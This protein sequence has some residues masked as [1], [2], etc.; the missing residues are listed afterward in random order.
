M[1]R[2]AAAVACTLLLAFAACLAPASGQECDSEHFR[3]EDGHCIPA[4]WRCDGTRDCL[5][6]TDEVGCPPPS[7]KSNQFL[8]QGEGL[9]IPNFW[10]CDNDEDCEDGSDEHQ[11]CPGRTCSSHQITCSN[12]ECIPKE[13]RCDHVRDCSDGTDEKD[14]QYP[15]CEQ[16]TCASGACY[17][18]SQK[19]DGRIDCRDSSDE[20][21]CTQECS[22]HEFQCDIGV[23][24]PRIYV[25]DH[26]PDCED[27]GDERSCA[28]ETCR[29]N[30]FT[31]SNGY[32][33]SQN[34]VCDGEDDCRD[35]G[36]ENGC[37]SSTHHIRE[38]YPGEWA[39]PESG[40][41]IPVLKVCDGTL[42]CPGGEDETNITK[43]R[44]C[45]VNLC[46]ILS[47]E[48][49][50]HPSPNGG[51]CHCPLGFI[52]DQ[53]NTRTCVDFN[54]CQIWGICDQMC[55]DR[56]G[57]HQCHC[58]EGYVLEHQQHCKANT[59]S[60]QASVIFSNGRDLLIG[61]IHGRT[62]SMLVESQN[63]G[64]AVGVDFHY[65]LHRVFWTDTVQDKV[66]SVDIN[67]LNIQEVVSLDD[68]ENLAVD[69]INNKLYLVETKVNRID[70]VNIDGSHR[71]T[72]ITENLGH[73]RGIAV[74]PTVGKTVVYGGSLIP[75]PFGISLFEDYVYFTDWTKMAVMKANKFTET[76]PQVYLQTSLRP[77]GVTVYHSLRQPYV[78]NPCGDNNG[79]CEQVCVLSHRT[80]NDG[81]GY[82]CRCTFGFSLDVDNRH[83]VGREILTANRVESVESLTFDWISKNLYWTDASYRSI[84][85]MRLADK[86]RRAIIQNLNNPRSIVVHPIAGYIF[87][88][89]WF[90]PAKI[91]R[92]WS[93]GSNLLPIVNTTLGWPNGLA[94]D[95]G[96]LR[97][98]WVDAFFDKI[99]HS[100]FDGLDRRNLGHIQQMTHPF[101]LTVFGD[102]VFFTDWRLGAIVRVR[103]M[104]GGDMRVIRSGITN[105]M[106]VKSY[107]ANTQTGS[108]Y[109][110]RPTH[111]NGDCSHFCFP[112]PNFQRVCGCPYGMNLTSNHL[113]CQEDPSHEP[114]LEQ[115]GAL[116]FP[117]S[118]GRCV[119]SHY[120]C[121]GVDDCHDNSD[122]HLCGKFNNSCASSAFTCSHGECIPEHWKCDK[123]NDCVDGSDEQNCPS[124]AP[125]SCPASLFTCDNNLCIPRSWLCDTDNDCADGSDEKNCEFTETCLPS[126]FRCP[127][128]R[129]IDLSFV[130]DGDKDCVD[131]SDENGCVINCT[132]SQFKCAS[133]GRCISNIYRCDGVFDCNDHSDEVDCSTRPP[134]MCHPDEFQ[135]QAD[136]VCIP[137]SWECDG[138]PDCIFGSDE[139]HGCAAKTCP[140]THFLCDN[141]NCIYRDWLCDGDND[142]R[143]MSDEKDCPTQ[144]FHCPSWQWQ[145]PGH[146]ICVNLSAVC[147]GI[148][149]CPN[150][151]DESPLCSKFPDHSLM[152]INSF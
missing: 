13:Y 36:D 141:G 59:S 144:A 19:C 37:E 28:Y 45:D 51:I 78:N 114:P 90:R 39:C 112:V 52:L 140:S 83:C 57:H 65:H 61:D 47:C 131:G 116:S 5:D 1:E 18:S 16:L 2:G 11:H 152:A 79:G 135:C 124:Q 97:L 55:E 122:E 130:C 138:H 70:M 54:D 42:D 62:F 4:T 129:C 82:R 6:D 8:C 149:D 9:C 111:P 26:Y 113:T 76:S 132:A 95:W 41:C 110:N 148:S 118:N 30:Q 74:D 33:I 67:G 81:L 123:Q 134:G 80:D 101:G 40:K 126:Q 20:S 127:D 27:G 120:R 125:T 119:P 66:F 60:E 103:K 115:C 44:F 17:N 29:G 100:T 34:M 15:T 7:C 48:Y 108:N 147:D 10:E 3:C 89:D 96:A 94:I 84:S 136:G 31:C 102:Y 68:P 63:H 24:I 77:F 25:C 49:Q 22:Q 72:L 43:G 106:H 87:F 98:Y 145:C 99:E 121:D 35:N 109:C 133:E 50:C 150:G 21:N 14:C 53:N 143:D 46:S 139:H 146:S 69:W 88:T 137:K 151:T 91:M 86:S 64:V 93:D 92:A 128:H 105:I 107:D 142:C 32:C 71:L 23:C 117:C 75:H 85:V 38:C 73:P 104:D 58:A 56:I 12:G